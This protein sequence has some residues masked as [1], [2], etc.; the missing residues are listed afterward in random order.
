M[1]VSDSLQREENEIRAMFKRDVGLALTSLSA[2]ATFKIT[3]VDG[4]RPARDVMVWKTPAGSLKHGVEVYIEGFQ[5]PAKSFLET[6]SVRGPD[7]RYHQEP[8]N[9]D[10]ASIIDMAA[11]ALIRGFGPYAAVMSGLEEWTADYLRA[12]F[13]GLPQLRSDEEKEA[14]ECITDLA[15]AHGWTV[16]SVNLAPDPYP[17]VEL[18][19]CAPNDM[20]ALATIELDLGNPDGILGFE[21]GLGEYLESYDPEEECLMYF[22]PGLQLRGR[23]SLRAVLKDCDWVQDSLTEMH[24]SLC[25]TV[26]EVVRATELAKGQEHEA[27][28]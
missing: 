7:G 4:I 15:E 23:P 9:G 18:E 3:S 25:V 2:T 22:Q 20:D 16:A 21:R 12:I 6:R 28:R 26:G 1:S 8:A 19:G 24:D 17:Y 11:K 13:V 14:L 27:K 5:I 10:K